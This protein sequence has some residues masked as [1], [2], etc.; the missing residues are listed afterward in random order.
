LFVHST[1]SGSNLLRQ[2]RSVWA[3]AFASVIAFMGIGLVDPILPTLRADLGA[4][5]SQISLLFT[6]YLFVMGAAMLVSGWVASR[7]GPKRTLLAGLAMVVLFSALAGSSSSIAEIVGFRA[8]WGLGNAMFVGTALAVIVGAAS[9]G[10]GGA[11]ILYESALGIGIATG[12]LLGG[13]LGDISWRGP[14]F[15][16]AVLMA[17][18]L[19]ATLTLLGEVARPARHYGFWEP[20]AALRHGGLLATALVALFYNVGFFTLLAYAPYPM[21]MTALQLG[22]VF[23]GWGL[24]VAVSSVVVAP[25]V[26]RRLGTRLGLTVINAALTAVLVIMALGIDSPATLA[27]CVV[28]SGFFSG[29]ANTLVT[30]TVMVIAPVD[31]PVAS[32]GYSFVRFM[33]GAVAPLIASSLAEHIAPVA[34]FWFGAAGFLVA[35]LVTISFARALAPVDAPAATDLVAEGTPALAD[36]AAE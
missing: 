24:L 2:P 14:F 27:A 6:S 17:V 31:R 20:F 21:K 18:A 29:T 33:G 11:I 36:V 23:F 7:L 34:A 16:V 12:P 15:G 9:G 25:L 35:A 32:A 10:I 19:I 3:V 28:V 26:Q 30:Q 4:T 13:V 22:W 8:G 1:T 5:P